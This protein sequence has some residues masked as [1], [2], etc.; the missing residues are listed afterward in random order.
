MNHLKPNDDNYENKPED[1]LFSTLVF[2]NALSNLLDAGQGIV[3]ESHND[4]MKLN[5]DVKK[6]IV[7]N[8]GNQ[9]MITNISERVDLR[10]GDMVHMINGDI[11]LN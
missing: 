7:H 6:V 10:E 9:I 8:T 1:L 2:A 5:S 4:M 3:V 11:M